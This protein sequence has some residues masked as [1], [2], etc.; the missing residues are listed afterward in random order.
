MRPVPTGALPHEVDDMRANAFLSLPFLLLGLTGCIEESADPEPNDF[1]IA[2]GPLTPSRYLTIDGMQIAAYESTGTRGP[3]VLLLHGNTSSASSF[4][5]IFKASELT[6]RRVVAID[7]PGYGN[8]DDSEYDV[9]TF[10]SVVA[11]AAVELGVDD[12]VM[13]GWSLGGDFLLQTSHLLPDVQGYFLFGTAPVGGG[14]PAISPFLTPAESYAGPVV[15]YGFIPDLTEAQLDDYV[16]AFFRPGYWNIPEFFYDDGHRTD[17]GTRAAVYAAAAGLDPNF[18]AEVPLVQA[19]T[20]PIALVHA[21]KDAFVRL[22]YLKAIA[23]GIPNLWKD[24]IVVVPSSGH[25]IQ[26]ER[27]IAFE[28]LL[29]AFIHDL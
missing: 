23:P 25:A 4:A 26:W 14:P 22:D 20:V 12:G 19:L 28:L 29:E 9:A 7:L 24:K 16:E 1:D 5:R 8:S 3:G 11:Q 18:V 15:N 10:T 6:R 17:P 21:E 2:S 27:P 13:V